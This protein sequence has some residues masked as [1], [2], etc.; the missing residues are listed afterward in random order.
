MAES[1]KLLQVGRR[2]QKG[3]EKG[4]GEGKGEGESEKKGRRIWWCRCSEHQVT[5]E[6]RKCT[7]E[8]RTGALEPFKFTPVHIMAPDSN[9]I[10]NSCAS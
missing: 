5:L 4:Q 2:S 7:K 10:L 1:Q 8:G 3:E 9:L 6:S